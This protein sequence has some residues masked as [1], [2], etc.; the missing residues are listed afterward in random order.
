[1]QP[2]MVCEECKVVHIVSALGSRE[3]NAGLSFLSP[4]HSVK[5]P[6]LWNGVVHIKVGFPFSV[7]PF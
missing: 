5:V 2:I 3:L 4:F 1:M 7:N 6:N